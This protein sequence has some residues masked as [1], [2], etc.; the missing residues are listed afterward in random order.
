MAKIYKWY[1]EP[2]GNI[3][4]VCKV[5]ADEL[6]KAA[7]ERDGWDKNVLCADGE[8]RNLMVCSRSEAR[9]LWDSQQDTHI[10][11]KIFNKVGDSKPRD[12]THLFRRKPKQ[13]KRPASWRDRQKRSD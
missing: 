5:Y 4:H 13:V 10:T 8:Y 7:D 12:C 2:L 6:G 1:I 11:I 3:A 9:K